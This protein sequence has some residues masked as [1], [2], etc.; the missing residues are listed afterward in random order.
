MQHIKNRGFTVDSFYGFF[1]EQPHKDQQIIRPRGSISRKNKQL[2]P[3]IF[4]HIIKIRNRM[5]KTN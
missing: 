2:S 4:M 3:N 5:D 1:M